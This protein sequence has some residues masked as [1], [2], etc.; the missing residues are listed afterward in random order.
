VAGEEGLDRGLKR[1]DVLDFQ[2]SPHA[3]SSLRHVHGLHIM[4]SHELG[5]VLFFKD[6]FLLDL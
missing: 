5:D 6:F 4:S 2:C 3:V 1:G